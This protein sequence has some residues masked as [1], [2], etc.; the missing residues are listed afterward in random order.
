MSICQ[1]EP[2]INPILPTTL[3]RYIAYGGKSNEKAYNHHT[4]LLSY[5]I[6]PGTLTTL[7]IFSANAWILFLG[8]PEGDSQIGITGKCHQDES[9]HNAALREFREETGHNPNRLILIGT[10]R[11][12]NTSIYIFVTNVEQCSPLPRG[13]PVT[14]KSD[15]YY[16][17]IVI[18]PYGNMTTM[19]AFV[20]SVLKQ[21]AFGKIHDNISQ[22]YTSPIQIAREMCKKIYH[23]Q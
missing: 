13:E 21:I 22:V 2:D 4:I 15:D 16:R 12:H 20:D 10:A 17:K 6:L 3:V 14:E 11:V 9:A 7:N 18:L 1:R 23:H 8:Y 5:Y 19:M